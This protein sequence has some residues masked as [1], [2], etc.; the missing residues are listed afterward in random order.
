M[1]ACIHNSDPDFSFV[2]TGGSSEVVQEV[3]ADLKID[4]LQ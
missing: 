2:R 4:G 3:L 1:Y